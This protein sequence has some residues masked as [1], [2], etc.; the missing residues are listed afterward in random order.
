M[1]DH[2]PTLAVDLEAKAQDDDSQEAH[3][4]VARSLRCWILHNP[5]TAV[6]QAI[7]GAFHFQMRLQDSANGLEQ[8]PL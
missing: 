7:K 5:E 3:Q 1:P 2:E 4:P 8:L 6:S